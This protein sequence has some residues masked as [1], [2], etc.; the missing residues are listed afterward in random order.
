MT[1]YCCLGLVLSAQEEWQTQCMEFRKRYFH[2][3]ILGDKPV[4]PPQDTAYL[5]FFECNAEFIFDAVFSPLNDYRDTT[6]NTY[7][8]Q[9]RQF[10]VLGIVSFKSNDVEH[11]LLALQLKENARKK[12][13]RNHLF[14]PFKDLTTGETT[15][16]GGRYLDVVLED[17]YQTQ[18]FTL[19]FNLSYN[20]LCAYSD[21]FNCPIPPDE[22]FL[23]IAI[24]AGEAKFRKPD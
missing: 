20:P 24:M 22:N 11:Q 8:G 12:W 19:D 2:D 9:I 3:Y 7:S 13:Y 6:I 15:Y 18:Y 10:I 21:G 16:G 23:E 1:C 5:D 4:Y 17:I 14:L